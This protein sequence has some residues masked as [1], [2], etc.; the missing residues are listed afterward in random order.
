MRLQNIISDLELKQPEIAAWLRVTQPTVSR[1]LKRGEESGPVTLL[2]DHL[3]K[4]IAQHG[5]SVVR[6]MVLAGRVLP[7]D[8]DFAASAPTDATPRPVSM[9]RHQSGFSSMG[10]F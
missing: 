5:V 6:E 7:N 10:E 4:M 2:L 8:D 1:M 3:E 9:R